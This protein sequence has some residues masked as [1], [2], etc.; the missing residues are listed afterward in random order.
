MGARVMRPGS[1]IVDWPAAMFESYNV[2][3]GRRG[4]GLDRFG[5][6]VAAEAVRRSRTHACH[7][8]Q[9]NKTCVV[10]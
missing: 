6:G 2:A 8:M 7:R 5:S 3:H 4:D 10:K 9:W 1:A